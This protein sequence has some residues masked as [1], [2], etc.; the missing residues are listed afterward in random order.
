MRFNNYIN[1]LVLPKKKWVT[2]KLSDIDKNQLDK[3]YNM[4]IDTYAKQGLEPNV[5]RA[6]MIR[7]KYK[8]SRLID[9]DTDVLPDA[10]I[11]YEDHKYGQ[12]IAL[13]GTD[14]KK[15]SKHEL[16]QELIK[17][18]NTK[19][20]WI[21]ASGKLANIIESKGIKWLEEENDMRILLP[22]KGVTWKGDGFYSRKLL[23]PSNIT[24]TKRIYGKP[25][26]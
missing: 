12:K 16:I 10:F 1:E 24:I 17:L 4:F 21:E 8:I 13:L 25:P 22:Y 3:I 19:G 11:I 18:L 14:D 5:K 9:L 26:I 7:E 15:E 20:W 2:V 23:G 6:E